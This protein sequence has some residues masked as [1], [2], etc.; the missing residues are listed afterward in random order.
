MLAIRKFC[1]NYKFI[2]L[3]WFRKLFYH[4]NEIEIEKFVDSFFFQYS[5]GLNYKYPKMSVIT[6]GTIF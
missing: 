4:L 3:F 1:K 6:L 2:K 5:I